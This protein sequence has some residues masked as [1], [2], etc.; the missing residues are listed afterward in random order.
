MLTRDPRPRLAVGRRR[1]AR[2]LP[3]AAATAG[4][5][6]SDDPASLAPADAPVYVQATVRPKG[7]LKA[8]IETLAST[9]SGLDD[10]TG[11]LI[12]T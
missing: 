3:P 12:G 1:R 5:S 8:N 7:K 2:A 6:S 9:V 11:R 10:P 4:V